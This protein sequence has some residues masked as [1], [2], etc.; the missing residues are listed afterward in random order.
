M[1][2]KI[3]LLAVC[4]P[5]ASGKTALGVALAK[6]MN[7]EVISCDSMQIYRGMEIGTAKP[8][9]EEM[10]DIPHHL[11]DFCD[12]E[13]TFSV[14]DYT[15][16][17]AEC[18]ADITA[19][20]KW[21]IL[22]GGT[23]LYARSLLRS[24]P[25]TENSRSE[26]LRAALQKEFEEKGIE[27]IYA[28]LVELDPE[29]AAQIHPNNTK[30]VIRALEYCLVAGEPFSAQAK[31]SKGVESNYDY[32]MICLDFRDRE[33]LY[34][35]INRRV[36]LMIRDGLLDEAKRYYEQYGL[37]GKTSVQAIGYKEL[38]PYLDGQCI[39]EEAIEN[40]K[41]ETRRYA[42]RQLTWFRREENTEW[43][44]VDDYNSA[45]SLIQAAQ[46]IAAEHFGK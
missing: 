43:L 2:K 4:G 35:R 44:C 26:E 10:G 30:R 19:R 34:D 5:T 25:F 6:A 40:I 1:E 23:G 46:R 8:T 16:R 28:R 12:P 11:L 20:G 36:D 15:T 21:P 24:V 27:E 41:K 38:F 32:K 3:K 18:I 45:E 33:V 9:K 29:G 39:L 7:G 42:K 13:T 17:A 31:A 14:V 22:V 37:R